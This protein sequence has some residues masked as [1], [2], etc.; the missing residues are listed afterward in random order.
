MPASVIFPYTIKS[1]R[2][3]AAIEEVDKGCS[4]FCVTVGTATRTAGVLIQIHSWLKSLGVN[5]SQPSSRLWLYA[6]LFGS[7]NPC[8]LKAPENDELPHSGLC[9]L[10]ESFLLMTV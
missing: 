7:I 2:R 5:L 3:R 9:C 8:W 4:E 6:G 1:S 10:C